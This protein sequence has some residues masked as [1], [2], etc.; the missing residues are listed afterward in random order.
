MRAIAMKLALIL[1]ATQ[2]TGCVTMFSTGDYFKSIG[3]IRDSLK[4]MDAFYDQCDTIYKGATKRSRTP[5]SPP[6][7]ELSD[8]LKAMKEHRQRLKSEDKVFNDLWFE[9]DRLA[10][11]R[12][13]LRSDMPEWPAAMKNRETAMAH[14][15]KA[16][17]IFDSYKAEADA[18]IAK[19]NAAGIGRVDSAEVK[20]KM[21]AGL[22]EMEKACTS[23]RAEIAQARNTLKDHTSATLG[24][25]QHKE[26]QEALNK[27]DA[28]LGKIE[29]LRDDLSASFKA[30]EAEVKDGEIW[31]GPGI[32]PVPA[33][34]NLAKVTATYQ[35]LA[36]QFSAQAAIVK[37]N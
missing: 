31:R 17:P 1:G 5:M 29:G 28:I 14:L 2:L 10:K 16:K 34:E 24:L 32:P 4:G 6:Y 7:P 12:G 11:N 9:F 15:D 13:E 26:K 23:V 35:G 30:F 25:V 27:M 36:D 33:L 20:Q 8:R 3:G 21:S 22:G 37:K 19:A 18:F